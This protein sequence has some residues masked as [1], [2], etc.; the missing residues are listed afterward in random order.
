MK[1]EI[2]KF[3]LLSYTT[4]FDV[5]NTLFKDNKPYYLIFI[6][7]FDEK[8]SW[9]DLL[10]KLRATNN[11]FYFILNTTSN[12]ELATKYFPKENIL[13]CN[14]DIMKAFHRLWPTIPEL[15]TMNGA[16]ITQKKS[17]TDFL[18]E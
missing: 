4:G 6:N 13:K 17:Y 14:D 11:H 1:A 15:V 18:K 3:E 5:T 8:I 16:V 12:L 9:E 10:K 7:Q 2:E